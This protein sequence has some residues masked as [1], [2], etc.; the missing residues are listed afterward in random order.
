MYR[1]K[2]SSSIIAI[3]GL[4][5]SYCMTNQ[6][7]LE[8][9]PRLTLYLVAAYSQYEAQREFWCKWRTLKWRELNV[10]LCLFKYSPCI[11][12]LLSRSHSEN[13]FCKQ[14]RESQCFTGKSIQGRM[15]G[16]VNAKRAASYVR[17]SFI[18]NRAII[19]IFCCKVFNRW[20]PPPGEERYLWAGLMW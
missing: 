16:F 12:K 1:L 18:N 20:T 5:P 11:N 13:V 15:E 14:K 17:H 4:L 2:S 9:S 6:E 19:S 3:W 7:D 10:K 8:R